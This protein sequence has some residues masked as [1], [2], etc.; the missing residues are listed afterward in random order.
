VSVVWIVL[1]V[2]VMA[3]FATVSK[4]DKIR[5]SDKPGTSGCGISYYN[6]NCF[7]KKLLKF[8]VLC[9]GQVMIDCLLYAFY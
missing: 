8:Q 2:K 7:R 4:K 1:A 6:F 9:S 5:L 3:N